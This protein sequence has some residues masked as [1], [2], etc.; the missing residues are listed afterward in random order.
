MYSELPCSMHGC[1]FRAVGEICDTHLASP[2]RDEKEEGV[3]QNLVDTRPT[4]GVYLTSSNK[5]TNHPSP[6]SHAKCSS[7]CP[8]HRSGTS[9]S[10]RQTVSP[11]A[12]P[13][14]GPPRAGASA[15]AR[16]TM[17]S[18]GIPM[19]V[20]T[21]GEIDELTSENSQLARNASPMPS[22]RAREP[23]LLA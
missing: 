10:L 20:R 4:S 16:L 7:P 23:A 5:G 1:T 9:R 22:C 21:S 19:K 18:C 11:S 2:S 13:Y 8:D 6:A 12:A 3:V 15:L 14:E 17:T